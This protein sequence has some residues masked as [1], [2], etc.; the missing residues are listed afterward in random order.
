MPCQTTSRIDS[1]LL[2]A[3]F[4]TLVTFGGISTRSRDLQ[5]LKA[6]LPI[7]TTPEPITAFVIA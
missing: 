2:N 7:D 5:L 6:P 3:L 1:Q 4:P